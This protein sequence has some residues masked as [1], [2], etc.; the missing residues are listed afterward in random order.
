MTIRRRRPEF[1]DD[2]LK[3]ILN[4]IASDLHAGLER[5]DGLAFLPDTKLKSIITRD[6]VEKLLS[7][8]KLRSQFSQSR[9]AIVD[10]ILQSRVKILA[11]ILF[12]KRTETLRNFLLW[13]SSE[14]RTGLR[15][16]RL[17]YPPDTVKEHLSEEDFQEFCDD[18]LL[19]CAAVFQEGEDHD[20]PETYF[21]NHREPFIEE[22]E[23]GGGHSGIVYAVKIAP[24][25]LRDEK[26][27]IYEEAI[28]LARKKF[29]GDY[30]HI[31]S[32]ARDHA[33]E[34][35][36]LK[37]L[38]ESKWTHE[39]LLYKKFSVVTRDPEQK[40]VSCS[41]FYELA[42][43]NLT[44]AFKRKDDIAPPCMTLE[45]RSR[46]VVQLCNIVEATMFVHSADILHR[47]L[48]PDNILFFGRGADFMLK[49][50]DYG[51]STEVPYPRKTSSVGG[52]IPRCEYQGPEVLDPHTDRVGWWTDSWSLACII[53]Y[54]LAYMDNGRHGVK[55]LIKVKETNRID[56]ESDTFFEPKE[57]SN[58]PVQLVAGVQNYCQE[59]RESFRIKG[60]QEGNIVGMLLDFLQESL[61]VTHEKRRAMEHGKMGLYK[62]V[63][64]VTKFYKTLVSVQ[65]TANPS[66]VVSPGTDQSLEEGLELTPNGSSYVQASS[67]D[68]T[69]REPPEDIMSRIDSKLKRSISDSITTNLDPIPRQPT[70]CTLLCKATRSATNPRNAHTAP[71]YCEQ[72]IKMLKKG[73][74]PTELCPNLKHR[75][76]PLHHVI[77]IDHNLALQMK[78]LDLLLSS[79]QKINLHTFDLE[80]HTSPLV[81]AASHGKIEVCTRLLSFMKT[82]GIPINQFDFFP[83]DS[84][85][86][87]NRSKIEN[88]IRRYQPQTS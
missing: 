81:L 52:A 63:D 70:G 77:W 55:S 43:C 30:R 51:F 4:R 33:Q 37:K 6:A 67:A 48:K 56:K 62:K 79:G 1:M 78:L 39:N 86:T 35:R 38:K 11:A 12:R 25:H 71:R 24:G 26:G 14:T 21:Q 88:I 53:I 2:G 41:L 34:N 47:D 68:E 64:E 40:I 87:E 42:T 20:E 74:S 50:A 73:M 28:R 45:D 29:G 27:K 31:S 58:E 22:K 8:I 76:S 10:D 13:Y 84:P 69:K 75:T 17:P 60:E 16:D 72:I 3:V 65:T 7:K 44:E 19:F 80:H 85:I 32:A 66:P 9:E 15:D 23:I 36:V 83:K 54:V 5:K 82:K 57:R 46:L 49:L 59:L 61:F 18:Q